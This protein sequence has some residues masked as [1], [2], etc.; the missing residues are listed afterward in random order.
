[1]ALARHAAPLMLRRTPYAV[2]VAG[3]AIAQ[4][5]PTPR[6]AIVVLL[7]FLVIW[8]ASSYLCLFVG[9][10]DTFSADPDL[11]EVNKRIRTRLLSVR[12]QLLWSEGSNY[13]SEPEQLVVSK[14]LGEGACGSAYLCK[15]SRDEACV[16]KC[17][18]VPSTTTVKK[19]DSMLNEVANLVKLHHPHIVRLRSVYFSANAVS[20]ATRDGSVE[21]ALNI[22]LEYAAGGTLSERVLELKHAHDGRMRFDTPLVE[23]WFG[24]LCAGVAYMHSRQVLH[25][26]LSSAN[27]FFRANGDLL[28]GDLG[29]SKQMAPD[30]DGS[31]GE[32]ADTKPRSFTPQSFVGTPSYMSPELL[33][34][35]AYGAPADAWAIGILLHEMLAGCRPFD[36]TNSFNTILIISN[37][38]PTN[39]AQSALAG[40]GHPQ[41]LCAIAS[42]SG[43]LNPDPT[44]RTKLD[45][46]MR[47]YPLPA[48]DQWRLSIDRPAL[49]T[50]PVRP[51]DSDGTASGASESLSCAS[52]SLSQTSKVSSTGDGVGGG[53]EAHVPKEC[54]SLPR[55]FYPR[56][57]VLS[58]LRQRLAG[59][60]MDGSA[61]GDV[62]YDAENLG[63]HHATIICGMG[64]TGKSTV[65]ASLMRDKAVRRMYERLCWVSV[66]Q[67]PNIGELMCT[68]LD[69]IRLRKGSFDGSPHDVTA[70]S[71][72]LKQAA[73]CLRVLVVLDDVWDPAAAAALAEPLGQAMVLITSRVH[74]LIPGSVE[75]A[76]N[77]LDQNSALCL[78]LKCSD[79][80]PTSHSVPAAAWELVELCGRLPLTLALAGAMIVEYADVWESHLVPM[81]RE[82]H[83]AALRHSTGDTDGTL[84][85][86]SECSRVGVQTME[87]RVITSSLNLLRS[88]GQYTAVALFELCAAFPEDATIPVAVFDVLGHVVQQY[89]EAVRASA[90]DAAETA[91]RALEGERAETIEAAVPQAP[92]AVRSAKSLELLL[93][94][95]LLNGSIGSGISMHDIV[96]EHVL[97]KSAGDS[98]HELQA[99]VVSALGAALQQSTPDAGLLRYCRIYLQ[100]HAAEIFSSP[101]ASARRTEAALQLAVSHPLQWVREKL[102]RGIGS[103]RIRTEAQ[104]AQAAEDWW[105]AGQL[106]ALASTDYAHDAAECRW[107]AWRV[108]RKVDRMTRERVELETSVIRSL[109]IKKDGIKILSAEHEQALERLAELS[110]SSAGQQSSLVKEALVMS[111]NSRNYAML[112]RSAASGNVQSCLEFHVQLVLTSGVLPV[113]AGL[114]LP[115]QARKAYAAMNTFSMAGGA[116]HASD[117]YV[118]EADFGAHGVLL[119]EVIGWY[120]HALHHSSLKS[121]LGRDLAMCGVCGAALLLR[122]GKI[123]EADRD[124]TRA[125]ADVRA[126]A[127]N[128]SIGKASWQTYRNDVLD[129]RSVRAIMVAARW[130]KQARAL[131]ECSPEGRLFAAVARVNASRGIEERASAKLRLEKAEAELTAHVHAM[132]EYFSR[133][134]MGCTWTVA[135][136]RLM[137]YAVG[138][139]LLADRSSVSIVS[140][141]K[142]LPPVDVLLEI[143]RNEKAWDV[144]MI[145]AQHPALACARVYADLNKW[146]EACAIAKGLLNV[147]AQ[148]LIRFEARYLLFC[149]SVATNATQA[150]SIERLREASVE[151]STA[152]Y[153]WLELLALAELAA[154]DGSCSNEVKE[155][156]EQLGVLPAN[157]QDLVQAWSK[158]H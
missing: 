132:D 72:Q 12:R 158:R 78:L 15:S 126:I 25:R 134:G 21:P 156:S 9:S 97:A 118:W 33:S 30:S 62:P 51:A 105:R 20:V 6:L 81:L 7:V 139:L 5:A 129:L 27:I 157:V 14:L 83:K 140:V 63:V 23:A 71:R 98:Y 31:S 148:P 88:K 75:I 138:T 128:V 108:L 91:E 50:K 37:G 74:H 17:V 154:L 54:P 121:A 67:T 73:S 95:S 44:L 141:A 104:S 135:S 96:R 100:Y 70:L 41:E 144:Y 52:S 77:V 119:S 38:S 45:D 43:L 145:G 90:S 11:Q 99:L 66:G 16:M 146:E 116:L 94:L 36:G 127:K 136:F 93:N 117:R 4:I 24:Q 32:P 8:V 103:S 1:M 149:G 115:E 106:W 111:K 152:G 124:V 13:L 150:N 42:Q 89:G 130:M 123:E 86:N 133:W 120:D 122:W 10:P 68:L 142:W 53:S 112:H 2:L 61:D 151:A 85:E 49:R 28:I 153:L 57:D 59:G 84:D 58:S 92:I 113:V 64:G 65:V 143:A 48:D 107:E 80:D 110:A 47:L 40:S 147:L 55:A 18:P 69:Q 39:E 76:C 101:L 26:D 19:I 22:I 46:L 137:A 109:I 35:R 60:G 131:F 34:G 114:D 155:K 79:I 29:I 56:A 87:D 102:G 3:L 82:G 125:A